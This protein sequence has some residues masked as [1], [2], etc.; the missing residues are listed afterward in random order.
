MAARARGTGP[1]RPLGKLP[2][3]GGEKSPLTL[4]KGDS[5]GPPL[6]FGGGCAIFIKVILPPGKGCEK[7]SSAHR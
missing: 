2:K 5:R 3:K 4:Q 1:R 7:H 6:C